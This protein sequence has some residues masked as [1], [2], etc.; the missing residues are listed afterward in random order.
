M[1]REIS[2][3]DQEVF[4]QMVT[5][6]YQ[7]EAVL[8][9]I[10]TVNIVSTFKEVTSNSPYAKAY[11]LE[12]QGLLAGYALLGLTFS[13]EA[14]GLV[15]WIEELYIKDEFRG[16]G[17]DFLNFIKDEFAGRAKRFRLEISEDNDSAERLYRRKGY[18]NLD[19]KQMVQDLD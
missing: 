2:P 19:Y 9:K 12:S 5:D 7:S 1:I 6:F 10:P 4:I 16:L 17:S 14:G 8:S 13:N 18:Q 11:I 15:V 3:Q